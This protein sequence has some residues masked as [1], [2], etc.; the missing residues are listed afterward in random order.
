VHFFDLADSMVET[1]YEDCH[2]NPIRVGD[3]IQI[4]PNN[5]G[6]FASIGTVVVRYNQEAQAYYLHWKIVEGVDEEWTT[7]DFA[8]KEG[9]LGEIIGNIE[10]TPERFMLRGHNYKN[11]MGAQLNNMQSQIELSLSWVAAF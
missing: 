11:Q 7:L 10:S 2:G 8:S 4:I 3:I 5:H 6:E 9:I 1:H